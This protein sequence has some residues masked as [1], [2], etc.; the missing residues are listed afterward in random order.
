M[1]REYPASGW[2]PAVAGYRLRPPVLDPHKRVWSFEEVEPGYSEEEALLEADRCLRCPEPRCVQGCPAHNAIPDFIAAIKARDL[3]GASDILR[4]TTDFPGI[5]GRVCDKGRQCEGSCVLGQEGGDATAIGHLERFVADW[6]LRSGHRLA[7][8]GE[9]K[10]LTGRRVAVVGSGPSG[11]AVAGTLA[12]LGHSVVVFEALPVIGGALAWGIPTFRLPQPVLTAE[13]DFLRALDVEFRLNARVGVDV[14]IEE[15]LGDGF[16]AVFLGAGAS[17]PTSAGVPGEDLEG[18]YN[19]TEFLSLAK[20]ARVGQNGHWKSPIIGERLAVIGAGNTAMDVAQT[21][22]RLSR[23]ELQELSAKQATMDVAETGMRLGFREVTVVYRRSE[24]EM[25]ARHEEIESAREE[26]VRFRFL[27]APIRFLGQ[28]GR[29]QAMECIEMAL[30]EP[31]ARGRP[32][33]VPKPGSEFVLEV[34]TVVMAL[35]YQIDRGL[36]RSVSGLQTDSSGAV[37]IDPQTGRTGRAGLW[38]GGDV[39]NGPDTVVRAMVNGRNAAADIHRY[40]QSLP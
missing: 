5:C 32:V 16:A 27:S 38:A 23:A 2:A 24:A 33:P 9:R 34:D 39:V 30:S 22:V 20:L 11:L 17:V 21:A 3:E 36:I 31:D 28:G 15:L 26:G 25:P 35:G 4:R 12:S 7:R 29:L 13:V 40:L 37:T 6:E 10:P 1:G 14:G 8:A 19:S 18:V